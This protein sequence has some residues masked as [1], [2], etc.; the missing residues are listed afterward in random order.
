V[1]FEL[2]NRETYDCETY[3]QS[4]HDD[5]S[6]VTLTGDAVPVDVMETVTPDP[7]EVASDASGSDPAP[8]AGAPVAPAAG[9]KS[10]P[11]DDEPSA[12]ISARAARLRLLSTSFE[13]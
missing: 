1:V 11:V 12:V 4:Y 7:D 13:V 3:K 6:V 10:A 8:A 2:E 5:G 9:A